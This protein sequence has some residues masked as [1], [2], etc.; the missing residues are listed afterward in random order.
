MAKTRL[1]PPQLQT[2]KCIQ[3]P[4]FLED[5]HALWAVMLFISFPGRANSAVES[6]QRYAGL[7]QKRKKAGCWSWQ[8][9][10]EQTY[11]N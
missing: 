10:P 2:R 5:P 9:H 11:L 7:T 3:D 1:N 8:A 6:V 4:G